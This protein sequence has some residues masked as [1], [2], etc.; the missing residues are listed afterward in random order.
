MASINHANGIWVETCMDRAFA[1]DFMEIQPVALRQRNGCP[2][3]LLMW[4]GCPLIP[5]LL[6]QWL[7]YG[8]YAMAP[9]RRSAAG[10]YMPITQWLQYGGR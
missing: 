5:L 9:L 10:S 8:D 4:L 7:H 2:M 6:R 3:S 1:V